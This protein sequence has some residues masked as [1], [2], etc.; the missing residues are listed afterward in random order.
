MKLEDINKK[1]IYTVPEKYFD[2]LPGRVQA[3]IQT[4]KPEGIFA[5]NWSLTYKIA[6]P[7]LAMVMLVFY[8]WYDGP[9][10]IQSVES[11]LTQVATD[12][13]VAYLETTDITTEEIIES[14]DFDNIDLDLT[15]ETQIMPGI[16]MNEESINSII[17]EFGVDEDLL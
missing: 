15:D 11:L 12:D 17:D 16:E 10:N 7:A 9:E 1:N 13:L 14:I 6:A 5:L 2:Q 8:F 3:R 4:K